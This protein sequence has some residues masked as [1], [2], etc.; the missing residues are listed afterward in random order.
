MLTL[1]RS[2]GS[3]MLELY[4]AVLGPVRTDYYL[5]VFTR[6]DAAGKPELSWNWNAALLTLNWLAFRRLGTQTLAYVGAL[7]AGVLLLF[8]ILPLVLPLPNAGLWGLRGLVLALAVA[9][10]G[11]LGNAWL[12]RA[13]NRTMQRALQASATLEEACAVLHKQA[14][15]RLRMGGLA[16]INL[17]LCAALAAVWMASPG[18]SKRPP[19]D[20]KME[21]AAAAASV[22]SKTSAP[23]TRTSQGVVQSAEPLAAAPVPAVA[24]STALEASASHV[25]SPVA[26]APSSKSSAVAVAASAPAPAP[27]ALVA[28]KPASAAEASAPVSSTAKGPYQI[29]VGLFANADNAQKAHAKLVDAGLPAQ[30]QELP[31]AKGPRTRVRVG[32]FKT[33]TEAD[34]AAQ[35]IRALKLDA[36]VV[37]G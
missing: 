2:D 3:A 24:A 37:G 6:F 28:A 20:S 10:P 5:R 23:V 15:T 33:R 16:A 8:G 12:Y 34:A 35:K 26:S 18:S 11:A 4:R 1:D 36:A 7:V 30:M 21:P 25:A 13:S 17:A 22:D 9:L 14:P 31:T 29:N 32:P 19:S 27:K